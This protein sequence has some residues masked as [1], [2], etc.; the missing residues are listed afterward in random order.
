MSYPRFSPKKDVHMYAHVRHEHRKSETALS[1][2]PVFHYHLSS[3]Y[4]DLAFKNTAH[5]EHNVLF[6]F[7]VTFGREKVNEV[8]KVIYNLLLT[9]GRGVI[10]R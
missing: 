9:N 3:F 6:L 4:R 7:S 10:E 5:P 1:W 8:L 2:F